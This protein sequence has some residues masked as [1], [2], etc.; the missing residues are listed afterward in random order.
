MPNFPRAADT[1]RQSYSKG[2][3]GKPPKKGGLC[4]Q[5]AP[6]AAW[7][8]LLSVGFAVWQSLT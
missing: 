3:G 5:V 1:L 8:A 4:I 7:P 2:S 6:F